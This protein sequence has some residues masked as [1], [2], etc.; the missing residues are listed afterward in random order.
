M[1]SKLLLCTLGLALLLSAGCAQ[2]NQPAGAQSA[3][4]QP[5]QSA[6]P[7]KGPES[8]ADLPGQAAASDPAAYI[9][10]EEAR[11]AALE[12]AGLE[13]SQIALERCVLE[14]DGGRWEYDVEFYTGDYREYDYEIDACTGA[15][16][17]YDYDAEYLAPSDGSGAVTKKV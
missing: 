7:P 3:G 16:I 1:K 9:G 14:L 2:P 13:E 15:V 17:S 12:H 11:R 10:E 4:S 8:G 6:A 5:S